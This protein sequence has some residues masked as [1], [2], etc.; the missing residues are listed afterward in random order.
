[1]TKAESGLSQLMKAINDETTSLKQMDKL[2]ALANVLDKHREASIQEVVY[3]LMGLAMTK[4]SIK[5]KYLSTV[6]PNF[7]DGL[8]RSNIEDLNENES[9]F[10]TSPHQ[11][12]ECRPLSS[13]VEEEINLVEEELEETYWDSLSLSEFWS[14]YEIAYGQRPSNKKNKKTNLIPLLDNKGFIRRRSKVAVLR[15]YISYNNDEDMARALLIL[16]YPFRNEVE[17]I[18]TKDVKQLL[19]EN[20]DIVEKNRK[21]FEKYKLMSDLVASVQ[22][23]KELVEDN[24]DEEE[25][26]QESEIETTDIKDIAKFNNW[27]K[28][29]AAKDLS[30]FKQLTNV[31]NVE[32]LRS[33]VSSLNNQQR[34][35]FDDLVE[36]C[37]SH[38]LNER[39]VYLFLTGNAGTGKSF[40]V[41]VLIEAVKF[42]KIKSGDE[43]QKPPVL[44]MAPTAN[45]AFIIGGKTIDSVL[46][47]LPVDSNKYSQANPS[48]MALMRHQFEELNMIV[49]DEV[50]MVGSM[51]LL[52][53]NYR[54]Q[55]IFGGTRQNEY[56]GGVSFIASGT[57]SNNKLITFKS[58]I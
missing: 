53:I 56:M 27:A 57:Y 31:C 40:V 30:K 50:S 6:H 21:L 34:R 32:Q 2:N 33:S 52:K 11:Y 15:Y 54:L 51:K 16:F 58:R 48:K 47:F 5:I 18:H 12:Y 41:K 7:R 23:E 37:A 49:C 26:L 38:D 9:V 20:I 4:S 35:I 55:D 45:A 36:R 46:G 24:V 1:M 29:Q 28:S 3:R 42:I 44:V 17:D 14:K 19:N 13:Q 22:S 43:L 39:P 10:H 8:L 25:K